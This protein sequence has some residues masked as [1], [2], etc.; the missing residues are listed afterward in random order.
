MKNLVSPKISWVFFVLVSRWIGISNARDV[1][2]DWGGD[3]FKVSASQVNPPMQSAETVESDGSQKKITESDG[4]QK[5]KKKITVFFMCACN[6][7]RS[8]FEMAAFYDIAKKH[9]VDGQFAIESCG[10]GWTDDAGNI[11]IGENQPR[12]AWGESVSKLRDYLTNLDLKDG[13]AY[14][15]QPVPGKNNQY[16]W[17]T[18]SDCRT[19]DDLQDADYIFVQE[20]K[21]KTTLQTI[22]KELNIRSHPKIEL[23]DSSGPKSYDI[24]DDHSEWFMNVLREKVAAKY[25]KIALKYSLPYPEY[26]TE[27]ARTR[28]V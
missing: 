9:Q 3:F 14:L 20:E 12:C 24:P 19:R 27:R 8:P 6:L 13:L 18:T 23:L 4:S 22:L 10:V 11:L 26:N 1:S 16:T 7:H 25:R 15:R 5:K 28:L 17:Y 21:H 2:L